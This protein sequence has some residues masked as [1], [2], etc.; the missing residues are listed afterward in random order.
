MATSSSTATTVAALLVTGCALAYGASTVFSTKS[1][2][3]L[4]DLDDVEENP[5]EC[6]TPELVVDVFDKLFMQMQQVV[7]QLSQQVQQLQMAGQSIPEKQLRQLLKGEFE[8]ALLAFQPKV[9]ED[10]DVDADCLEEATWEFLSTPDDYPKVKR[11]VERFQNLYQSISGEEV[12]GWTPSKGK[13]VASG[14]ELSADE[15][16]KAAKLYF[17]T[18]TETMIDIAKA[19]KEAG[20][21]LKSQEFQMEAATR[22]NEAAEDKIKKEMD[23]SIGEFR[24]AVEKHQ[25]NPIVGQT[26]GMLQ[27]K[28]QQELMAAG[29]P[30][31]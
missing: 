23:I 27:M 4:D 7:L 28:Q 5:D 19:H 12:V 26:L 22:S 1:V 25:R 2:P 3:S 20:K 10:N 31:M 16:M 6:I 29:L 8:R 11:A 21:D 15:L 14:R 17:E 30:L 13:S 9:Y 18:I 24:S